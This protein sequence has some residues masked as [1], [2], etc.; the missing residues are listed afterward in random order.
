M[1]LF[2]K[3]SKQYLVLPYRYRARRASVCTSNVSTLNAQ[4]LP[5]GIPLPLRFFRTLRFVDFGFWNYLSTYHDY[6]PPMH[7]KYYLKKSICSGLRNNNNL[8]YSSALLQF[9]EWFQAIRKSKDV[10]VECLK[11]QCS[12][13]SAR[14]KNAFRHDLCVKVATFKVQPDALLQNNALRQ[15]LCGVPFCAKVQTRDV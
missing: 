7:V 13:L 1:K 8:L 2:Q 9:V 10:Q 3:A 6:L 14:Q 12:S 11:K 15:G 4:I 5:E